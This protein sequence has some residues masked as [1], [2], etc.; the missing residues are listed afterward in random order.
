MNERTAREHRQYV[1]MQ[2]SVPRY[3]FT[4]G[5]QLQLVNVLLLTVSAPIPRDEGQMQQPICSSGSSLSSNQ[6]NQYGQSIYAA[7]VLRSAAL[8]QLGVFLS[9]WCLTCLMMQTS[10]DCTL[11]DFLCTVSGPAHQLECRRE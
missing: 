4:A 11:H 9:Y 1:A 2:L 3:A 6:C 7:N 10:I 5:R 8:G